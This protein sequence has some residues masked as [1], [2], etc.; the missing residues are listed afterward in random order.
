[1]SPAYSRLCR[2]RRQPGSAN[3]RE[4]PG[5][6]PQRPGSRRDPDCLPPPDRR[7]TPNLGEELQTI[8]QSDPATIEQAA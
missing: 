6:D 7:A 1:M 2:P 8:A 3:P 5:L 4:T